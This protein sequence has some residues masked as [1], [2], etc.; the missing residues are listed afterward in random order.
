MHRRWWLTSAAALIIGG[1]LIAYGGLPLHPRAP[2]PN[3]GEFTLKQP[4]ESVSARILKRDFAS[5]LRDSGF[6]PESLTCRDDLRASPGSTSHCDAEFSKDWK[7]GTRRAQRTSSGWLADRA[8]YTVTRVFDRT[9]E[10][11]VTPGLGAAT[12]ENALARDLGTATYLQCPEDG[13]VGTAGATVSCQA[14]YSFSDDCSDPLFDKQ[15]RRSAVSRRCT[16]LVGVQNVAGF[17][18]DLSILHVTP[19]A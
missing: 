7:T 10:Y 1:L 16:L 17:S 6:R 4:V 11:T 2:R 18:L 3:A 12:L 8:D 5:R 15:G 13:I 9:V 14:N 19:P